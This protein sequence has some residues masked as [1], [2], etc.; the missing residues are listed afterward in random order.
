[1]ML[2]IKYHIIYFCFS[3]RQQMQTPNH[4]AIFNKRPINFWWQKSI[5]IMDFFFSPC[6]PVLLLLSY[7]R[8]HH[9]VPT[10]CLDLLCN[11]KAEVPGPDFG[12]SFPRK[13]K[14]KMIIFFYCQT[15]YTYYKIVN[16]EVTNLT[17][18]IML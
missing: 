7:T 4:D 13:I 2:Y 14:N 12:N 15:N 3:K 8:V 5:I 17:T 11:T 16:F 1:M 10:F 6:A 18:I 9:T